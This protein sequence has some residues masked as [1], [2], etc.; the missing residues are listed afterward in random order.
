[1]SVSRNILLWA[2]KNDWLKRNVP[3]SKSVRR[4]VMRF[5][6]GETV[7]DAILAGKE[8][9]KK[10]IPTTFTRLGENIISIEEAEANT[11]EY[12]NLLE[13]IKE[14][15]LNIEISLKLTHIGLDL[16]FEKTLDFFS[17]IAEK[18]EKLNNCLFI[19]IEDSSYVDKTIN[20]YKK[21]KDNHNNVGL[22][23]QSYLH[24]T[25]DD[26]KGLS[27]INPWI[28]LVKGAYKEPA[29]IAF[30][31][32]TDVNKNYFQISKYLLNQI[33]EKNLR[34]AFATHDLNLQEQIKKE[35]EKIGLTKDKIEFQMLYGIKTQNQYK[36]AEEGYKIRTLISYGEHW[37]PW[38]VRRLAERPANVFFVLKNVLNN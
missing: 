21:I 23:L 16:S 37:Y 19:D 35:S 22:C 20:F 1:M 24:R 33:A 32:L 12:M 30:K 27:E 2:S 18:A 25:M 11:S 9:L 15:N 38:Y 3:K 34:V 7:E 6:P 5:M 36:L 29:S 8:L 13:R 17:S 26:L 10:N 14:E 4:A 31:K 28:R